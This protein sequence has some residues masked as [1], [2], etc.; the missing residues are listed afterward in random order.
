[1]KIIHHAYV[2]KHYIR[3]H[4]KEHITT[5]SLRIHDYPNGCYTPELPN[6]SDSKVIKSQP[7]ITNSPFNPKKVLNIDSE[8][9]P[10]EKKSGSQ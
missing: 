9:P 2:D 1:M 4:P 7:D 10:S 6:L 5:G 8:L 3:I